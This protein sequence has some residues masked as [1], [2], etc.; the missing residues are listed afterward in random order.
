MKNI[1]FTTGPTQL[2]DKVKSYF[3]S[4]IR[5]NILSF[6]H[7]SKDFSDIL[8]STVEELKKLL[9][10]P[11]S[12]YVFFLSSGT[13]CMERIIQNLVYKKSFHFINGYFAER[14]YNI[15]KQ[16][17]KSPKFIKTD[18]GK[19]FDFGEIKIPDETELICITHNETS[20]G[21]ALNLD[22]IYE[23]KKS[24]KNKLVALDI[25][26]SVPYY[27]IDFEYIDSAFFS[28]QKGFGMPSGLG[29]LIINKKCLKKTKDLNKKNINIGTYNNFLN[30][31]LN[32]DK[33]QT[34]VTPNIL[35][36]YLLG[37]ICKQLNEYGIDKIRNET[38]VKAKLIYNFLDGIDKYNA[39][40]S[41]ETLRSKTTIVV[42]SK[43]EIDKVI[44]K[45]S[46]KNIIVN[47]GYKDF[48]NK[49][50]R[51]GNFPMHK[52]ENAIRLVNI[53]EYL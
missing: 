27:R 21:V 33:N 18:F 34:T 52:I 14:F 42:E 49:H 12:H 24:H 30:L 19:G 26:T 6:S 44:L 25:V 43:K 5:K 28:V 37:R 36:I 23:I 17:K 20:T 8:Q 51:I 22:D 48:K 1:Y 10:I 39:F 35:G 40:V 45:L 9:E 7:R 32:A 38:E 11:D 2:N 50:F 15:S 3:Y 53:L 31:K 46:R 47:N 29:V 16:L 4:A 13:E 41:D